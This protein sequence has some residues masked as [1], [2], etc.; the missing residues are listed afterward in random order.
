[1]TRTCY[2]G[3]LRIDPNF[4]REPS[5]QSMVIQ[6]SSSNVSNFPPHGGKR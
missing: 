4:A 2:F 1:M 5:A 3:G 6:S